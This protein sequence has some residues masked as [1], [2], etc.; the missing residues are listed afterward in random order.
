MAEMFRW[1]YTNAAGD[2][3]AVSADFAEEF[4]LDQAEAESWI[5]DVFSDLLAEGVDDIHLY[6]GETK[7]YGPMSLHPAE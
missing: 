3:V 7:V 5:G 4:F 6:R 1:A 2:D